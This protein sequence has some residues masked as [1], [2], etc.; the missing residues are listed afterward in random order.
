MVIHTYSFTVESEAL[1]LTNPT[2]LIRWMSGQSFY[3]EFSHTNTANRTWTFPDVTSTI[4][5]ILFDTVAPTATATEGTFGWNTSANNLYVNNDGGTG[6]TFV[7]GASSVTGSG[8]NTRVAYWSSATALTS[9]AGFTFDGATL[10]LSD[11]HATTTPLIIINQAST[12]DSALR[13]TQGT[14]HSYIAGIDNSDS[15][16]WKL[17]YAASGTAVLG[18]NDYLSVATTGA[19][20]IA[21]WLNVGTTTDASAQGDFAAGVTGGNRVVYTVSSALLSSTGTNP[22]VRATTL[23]GASDAYFSWFKTGTR[24]W[25][26]ATS[27]SGLVMRDESG[28]LD[29]VTL[30]AATGNVGIGTTGP[31]AKLDVLATS[32]QLRLTYT[33]G[34]VYT[35]FLTGSDGSLS[36]DPAAGTVIKFDRAQSGLNL[37]M[38]VRNSSNTASSSASF[39]VL[40]GGGTA[41]DPSCTF[42][43]EGVQAWGFGIDN[44]DSDAFK[45]SSGGNL[46]TND[47]FTIS[48]AGVVTIPLNDMVITR[49]AA[50]AQVD[51]SIFNTDNTN[52]ASHAALVLDVGGSSGGD[53]YILLDIS[54]ATNWIFGADNSDSDSFKIS[55]SA[56]LGSSDYLTITTAGLVTTGVGGWIGNEAG[57]DVDFRWESDDESYCLMVEGTLNNIVLCANAEPGFNTM[58]GGVFLAEANVVPTGNPTA[59]IYIYVEGGAGKARGT[60]GTITTWAPAEP[61]CEVC[62]TDYGHEWENKK[63][64]RLQFCVNCMAD[65]VAK[66][67]GGVL[68]KWIKR[69]SLVK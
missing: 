14:A 46:G 23:S 54:G 45:I 42:T 66:N 49:S 22:F 38:R 15:D 52:A 6:W 36:I 11:S 8:A 33:D 9:D 58:D 57:A 61:H 60:G 43:V 48:A 59:G 27:G 28:A 47:C 12:G 32:T 35:D 68:P 34:S 20:T 7:G 25:R 64:G 65:E 16:K 55:G 39:D 21:Q 24:E 31:D 1:R 44:S 17:S 69:E 51:L 29:V 56:S 10:T 37:S 26:I 19:T 3:G 40:V 67:N 63:W 50:G 62:G 41:G 2:Q 30:T 18:T 4:S 53:T 5:S 13:W